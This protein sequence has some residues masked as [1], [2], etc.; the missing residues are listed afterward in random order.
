MTATL[1]LN[2]VLSVAIVGA[3]L[4]LL[5]W[6]IVTDRTRTA[7]LD[8]HARRRARV[9]KPHSVSRQPASPRREPWPA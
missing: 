1:I 4:S 3:I 5:V 2:L 8:H 6:G 9:R 7:S